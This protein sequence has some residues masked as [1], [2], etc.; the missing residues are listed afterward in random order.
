MALESELLL[1]SSITDVLGDANRVVLN[2]EAYDLFYMELM[3]DRA[4]HRAEGCG[5]LSCKKMVSGREEA[6][7]A[8]QERQQFGH[9][10][11][12][13]EEWIMNWAIDKY[14]LNG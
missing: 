3:L 13:E 4:T 7:Y 12:Q 10:V 9:G 11:D 2:K 1:P 8:E 5:C 6:L 14:L